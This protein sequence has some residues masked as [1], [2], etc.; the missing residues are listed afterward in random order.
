MAH[1]RP[2]LAE[3]TFLD[4]SSWY[5]TS[6]ARN[7]SA[8]ENIETLGQ[9]LSSTVACAALTSLWSPPGLGEVV[10]CFN[11]SGVHIRTK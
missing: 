6:W 1:D 8:R 9:S 10:L 11:R 5:G 4:R 7:L 3:A 2:S